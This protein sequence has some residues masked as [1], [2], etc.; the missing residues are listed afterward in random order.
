MQWCRHKQ[1]SKTQAMV[2]LLRG[3]MDHNPILKSVLWEPRNQRRHLLA[4]HRA[5]LAVL[6]P[7]HL[8]ILGSEFPNRVRSFNLSLSKSSPRIDRFSSILAA[9]S[10]VPR[11]RY[12]SLKVK[13]LKAISSESSRGRRPRRPLRIHHYSKSTI[14]SRLP[15]QWSNTSRHWLSQLEEITKGYSNSSR[16]LGQADRVARMQQPR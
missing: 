7:K 13:P 15:H 1:N 16:A 5:K 2:V 9:S 12:L 14:L 3:R 8:Q 6:L 11:F 4:S 10:V